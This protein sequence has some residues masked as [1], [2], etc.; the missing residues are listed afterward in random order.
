MY[1]SLLSTQ[2]THSPFVDNRI[3]QIRL[4]S[5]DFDDEEA[6]YYVLGF[7]LDLSSFSLQASTIVNAS[8]S[9]SNERFFCSVHSILPSGMQQ[10]SSR[11]ID[12]QDAWR[13]AFA[14]SMMIV[15]QGVMVI[16]REMTRIYRGRRLVDGKYRMMGDDFLIY[17]RIH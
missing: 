16:D 8:C 2:T 6:E 11:T 9:I 5:E 17:L 1:P 13:H 14:C 7:D 10:L 3:P 15:S 4:L 12:E